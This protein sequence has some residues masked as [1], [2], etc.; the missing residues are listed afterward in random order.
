VHSSLL[1]VPHHLH[2]LVVNLELL[3]MVDIKR[4]NHFSSNAGVF[5]KQQQHNNRLLPVI[6]IIIIICMI[7]LLLHV[8]RQSLLS[9]RFCSRVHPRLLVSVVLWRR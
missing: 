5:F 3:W 4:K 8:T 2:A 6:R 1:L 7:L 9:T